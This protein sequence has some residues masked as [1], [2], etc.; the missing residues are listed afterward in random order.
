MAEYRVKIL[1]HIEQ[2]DTRV[3]DVPGLLQGVKCF[4][5]FPPLGKNLTILVRR[6]LTIGINEFF[7]ILLRSVLL[8]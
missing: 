8:I 5:D 4:I 2:H 1:I 6:L 3:T 7:Q